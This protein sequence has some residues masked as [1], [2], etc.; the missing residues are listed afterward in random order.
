MKLFPLLLI[1]ILSIAYIV[2]SGPVITENIVVLSFE[3]FAVFL[4]LWTLWTIKFEKF[5]LHSPKLRK[6]RL[7]PKGPFVYVR[8][9]VYTAFLV[10]AVCWIINYVSVI[11]L[12]VLLILVVSVLL[13]V[14]YY[15]NILSRKLNDFG[16][17][18]QK[19]YRLIPFVY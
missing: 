16:L 19:T 2:I 10:L 1:Q 18:K 7:V 14:N 8:H 13:T 15:E 17:Y 12:V 9:P 4:I 6:S 11:R 5:S 3:V